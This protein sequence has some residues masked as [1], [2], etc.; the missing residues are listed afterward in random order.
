MTEK[1]KISLIK[2]IITR[3]HFT[4]VSVVDGLHYG[5]ERGSLFTFESVLSA[6]KH[7]LHI[8]LKQN[9]SFGFREVN[10][11]HTA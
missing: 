3:L 8:Q 6:K 4:Y 9:S 1:M 11:K 7:H 10:F 2:P 5:Q